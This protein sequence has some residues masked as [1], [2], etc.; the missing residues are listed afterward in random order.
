M[1][2]VRRFDLNHMGNR[3]VLGLLTALAVASLGISFFSHYI[4]PDVTWTE[5]F[6]GAFQNFSTEMMGA[7]VTFW[8][9]EL[10]LGA[11][12]REQDKQEAHQREEQQRQ[13]IAQLN[14]QQRQFLEEANEQREQQTRS[15]LQANAITRL[16]Q[17]AKAEDTVQR[18]LILDEMKALDLLQDAELGF[19]NLSD[20]H[21]LGADLSGANL[22]HANLSGALLH[23]GNLLGANL[24]DANLSGV[25]FGEANLSGTLLGGANLTGADLSRANLSGAS[26]LGAN[27][28]DAKLS[29]RHGVVTLPDGTKWTQETDMTRFTDIWHIRYESTLVLINT[30]RLDQGQWLLGVLDSNGEYTCPLHGE[31]LN[32]KTMKERVNARREELGLEPLR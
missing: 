28:D 2:Q 21:L 27:L 1:A 16:Q 23:D 31:I 22:Q 20:A 12:Q 15:A 32:E 14:E 24:Q 10:I 30:W 6:D 7:I 8:L 18:Q 5:W 11:R 9:F 3:S 29:N 25:D 17:A 19:A 26:L 4:T 13:F